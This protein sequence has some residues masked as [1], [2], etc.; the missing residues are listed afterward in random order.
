MALAVVSANHRHAGLAVVDRLSAV[1]ADRLRAVL[2]DHAGDGAGSLDPDADCGIGGAVVLAT[3]NRLEIYL[4]AEYPATAADHVRHALARASGL[5]TGEVADSTVVLE[6][7]GATRHL[8]EVAS[9]LDSMVVGE[10]EIVGQVRRSLDAARQAGLTTPLLER[11]FQHASRTSREVAVATDLARA[12]A[13]VASVALDLA[14]RRLA[15][16][17]ALLVGTGAYA[18]VA[19]AALRARGVHD[20]EVWSASGRAAAFAESHDAVAVDDLGAALARADIVVTCRGTGT[21]VLDTTSVVAALAVRT[22]DEELVVVDLA[23][24][25]DVDPAVRELPGVRLIDL[26]TVRSQLPPTAA[27]EV[28]HARELVSRGLERLGADLASRVVDD[29]VVALRRRVEDA[30][31]EELTRLPAEGQVS[32][33][34]AARAL[35]RLAARLLHTPTVHARTAARDGRAEEHVEALKQV[36][37][38]TVPA[39]SLN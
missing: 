29:A 16:E 31:A 10:R 19:L 7:D 15:G 9:G 4:D 8:F 33:E 2:A 32:S 38:V 14:G 13:S 24:N 20:V 37:G 30:V 27:A 35:R 3:C 28:E 21:V 12:G 25:H 26:E 23:L 34:E 18:G 6:G 36:L 11:T 5:G 1:G 39:G 17:R 22:G